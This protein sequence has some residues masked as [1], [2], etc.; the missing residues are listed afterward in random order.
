M[1]TNN[2]DIKYFIL[3]ILLGGISGTFL[4][5]LIG[6]NFKVVEFLKTM[7]SLGTTSP[8]I[9]DLKVLS[10]TFG[11]KFN[12]NIMSMVGIILAII[13]YRKR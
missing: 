1:G 9:L 4:G 7:Y 6:D 12:V 13:V 11:I 8:I 3:L 10:L 2:K 5:E